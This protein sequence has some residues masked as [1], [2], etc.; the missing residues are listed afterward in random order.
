MTALKIIYYN[1]QSENKRDSVR[2]ISEPTTLRSY[3]DQEGKRI[4]ETGK[5]IPHS[6]VL[7]EIADRLE[8]H[9]NWQQG[10]QGFEGK[11]IFQDLTLIWL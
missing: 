2:A 9:Y 8:I 6:E 11:V 7:K 5:Y 4:K 10:D 3:F 1:R